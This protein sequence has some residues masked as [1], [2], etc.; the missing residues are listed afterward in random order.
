VRAFLAVPPDP[1]WTES[2][3]PL[4]G[5]L[6]ASLP[7]ASW[8]RADAWHL[9]L[10]FLGEISPSQAERLADDFASIAGEAGPMVLAKGDAVVFPPRGRP[11]V[12][13]VGFAPSPGV[14]ALES[15]AEAAEAAVRRSGLAPEDRR[16][17]PHLTLAR[18]RE[19]WS[20]PA[21]EAFRRQIAAWELPP[22][23]AR[24]CVL[25]E[26]RLAPSGAS[27]TPIRTFPFAGARQAVGA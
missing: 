5:P 9:T 24:S 27:H 1:A 10:K 2:V 22:W 20:S 13:G 26:S 8:T 16:F 25:Y 17:H 11:R 15:L 23:E 14:T 12:L 4:A 7:R 3:G 18:L 21:V 19:P 6:R